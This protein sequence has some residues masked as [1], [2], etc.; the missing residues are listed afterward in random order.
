MAPDTIERTNSVKVVLGRIRSSFE[1]CETIDVRF[2]VNLS[3]F[4]I[5]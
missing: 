2:D 1:A 4:S 3:S 5:D